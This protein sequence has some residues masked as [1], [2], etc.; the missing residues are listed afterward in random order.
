MRQTTEDLHSE[1]PLQVR[2]DY[3]VDGDVLTLIVDE[4]LHVT[5]V[6]S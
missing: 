6:R 1:D 3:E 2:I 5:D 4:E